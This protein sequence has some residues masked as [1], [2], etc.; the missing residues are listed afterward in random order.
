VTTHLGPVGRFTWC[1]LELN[2]NSLGERLLG[3]ERHG[4]R[5][6]LREVSCGDCLAAYAA[7][8]LK[9]DG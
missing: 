5:V 3:E 4:Y 6:R 1:G 8:R 7:S 2:V 9:E